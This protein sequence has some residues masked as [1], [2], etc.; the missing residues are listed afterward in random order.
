MSK[1]KLRRLKKRCKVE[2]I[3]KFVTWLLVLI[4]ILFGSTVGL[5]PKAISVISITI[6]FAVPDITAYILENIYHLKHKVDVYR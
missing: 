5:S 3:A 4:V 6:W 1:R 2:R